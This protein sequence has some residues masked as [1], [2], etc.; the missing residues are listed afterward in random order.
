[1]YKFSLP[2]LQKSTLVKAGIAVVLACFALLT[3]EQM[4]ITDLIHKTP[5]SKTPHFTSPTK[6][7]AEKQA[8]ESATEKQSYLDSTKNDT[9]NSNSSSAPIS[10]PTSDFTL[11]SS[12]SGDIVTILTKARGISGGECKMTVTKGTNTHSQSATLI[13]QPEFSSCAGFSISRD[14]L[15]AGSWTVSV[16]ITPTNST[17]ITKSLTLEVN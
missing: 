2:D 4:N 17:A 10:S 11:T 8:S 1:M 15:G 14:A 6:A 13:Y 9:M 3:L 12:Q 16:T 5:D 7:E